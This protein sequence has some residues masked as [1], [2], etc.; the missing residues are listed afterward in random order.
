M[1]SEIRVGDR[2]RFSVAGAT[3]TGAVTERVTDTPTFTVNGQRIEIYDQGDVPCSVVRD[4][5]GGA[6]LVPDAWGPVVL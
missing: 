6:W 4:A 5:D 3:V 2:V 1:M